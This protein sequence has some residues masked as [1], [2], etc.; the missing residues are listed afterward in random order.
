MKHLNSFDEFDSLN[1]SWKTTAKNVILSAGLSLSLLTGCNSEQQFIKK[2]EKEDPKKFKMYYTKTE[3]GKYDLKPYYKKLA[4]KE[5]K[6]GE[7]CDSDKSD[8]KRAAAT[9]GQKAYKK[10][11]K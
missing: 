3:D 4:N 1:E 8:K 6:K 2:M 7:K 10:N 9:V 5:E 11:K